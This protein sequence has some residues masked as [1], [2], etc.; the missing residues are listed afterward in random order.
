MPG[1][2]EIHQQVGYIADFNFTIAS[3]IW[4]H[5]GRVSG[6]GRGG[7]QLNQHIPARVLRQVTTMAHGPHQSRQAR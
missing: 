3:V 2:S 1:S 5:F 6:R 7:R 4:W